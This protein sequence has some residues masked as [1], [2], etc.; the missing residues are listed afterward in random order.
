[1]QSFAD[2]HLRIAAEFGM[3]GHIAEAS[4]CKRKGGHLNVIVHCK[5]SMQGLG[6]CMED[7]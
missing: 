3:L 6:D 4:A 1:M 5:G 7:L 2:V